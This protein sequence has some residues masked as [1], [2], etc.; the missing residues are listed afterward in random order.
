M[1]D[2]KE[3][4][5]RCD[6]CRDAEAVIHN[7]PTPLWQ[8]SVCEQCA[9]KTKERLRKVV[10]EINRKLREYHERTDKGPDIEYWQR[11]LLDLGGSDG[12]KDPDSQTS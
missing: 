2:V 5:R 7:L 9:I 3:P 6:E 12:R 4:P 1:D 8:A 10:A 11:S